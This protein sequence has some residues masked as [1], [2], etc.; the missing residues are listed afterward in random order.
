MIRRVDHGPVA[1]DQLE[2]FGVHRR[3]SRL[4]DVTGPIGAG[5][6]VHAADAVLDTQQPGDDG[7]ESVIDC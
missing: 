6:I 5:P 2:P 7:A 3:A 1:R 4:Q